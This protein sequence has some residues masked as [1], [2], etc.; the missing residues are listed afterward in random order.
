[1]FKDPS[2]GRN[3]LVG[4]VSEKTTGGTDNTDSSRSRTDTLVE[5]PRSAIEALRLAFGS[6][7]LFL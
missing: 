2:F 1:M 5:E 3:V 6:G 4:E 7:V